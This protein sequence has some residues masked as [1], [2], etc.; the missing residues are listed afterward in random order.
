MLFFVVCACFAL[1]PEQVLSGAQNGLALCINAVIPSLLPF[2]LVSSCVIK[3]NFSRPLG[4]FLSKILSPLTGISPSGCVCFVT[5][6][7]GGYGTG[8]RAVYES[9]NEKQ[10]SKEEAER[11]L[12]FCNNAGPL[13][14][15]ATVGI[16]FF[17]SKSIGMLLFFIQAVTALIC[18]RVLAG[19]FGGKKL[20]V[21]EEWNYYKK[22]KPSAGEL[23]C[24]SA[25]ESGGAIINACV[26]VITFS[27]IL[28]IL[29]FGEYSFLAGILE[30][31]RGTAELSRQGTRALPLISALL[32]W[33]GMSVHFQ[34]SALCQGKFSTK[35]YYAGKIL[36]SIVAYLLTKAV[37]A[38]TYIFAFTALILIA[39]IMCVIVIKLIFSPKD[40][41]QR[42]FRQRQHS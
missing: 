19:G 25:I 18:A 11:L 1:F 20:K 39:L 4:A 41:R 26:F 23:I 3:S 35:I 5:G 29:P 33:G 31:T 10:I 28:E 34:A 6:L 36:A 30:V 16:G 17:S 15:M 42:V 21:S 32:S 2:M 9:Y 27:A 24:T 40:A 14:I 8:A 13:F 22:N 12:A 38:D 37:C 7:L